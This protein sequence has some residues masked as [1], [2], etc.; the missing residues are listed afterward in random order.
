M[1][2]LA[3]DTSAKTASVAIVDEN[4]TIALSVLNNSLTH[5]QTLMPMIN[6]VLSSC[7]L[8]IGDIDGFACSSGPGSFTGLRIGI[9][10]V[11][12][13][14]YGTDKPCVGVS[15]L[16]ALAYNFIG[17]ESVVCAVMDARCNQ[18]YTAIFSS[19]N[20]NITRLCEDT[21]ISIDELEVMLKKI[22][23]NI[24]LVGDGAN[25]CYNKLGNENPRLVLSN[26]LL[27]RQNAS[28]VG[29]VAIKKI[30]AGEGLS[31]A[32]LLPTY[33]RLPQAERE[34]KARNK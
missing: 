22:E 14:S 1:K 2:I 20:G 33:L 6:F 16:E 30:V 26:D 7:E 8:Q 34:L 9:G 11:K 31:S 10:A 15:T 28:S 18:V 4:G 23:K 17:I 25:L 12:G 27:V 24:F 19:N 29:A 13:L 32:E 3:A 21:A 5:S